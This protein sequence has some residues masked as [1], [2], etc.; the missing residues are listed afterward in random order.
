MF[1]FRIENREAYYT[2]LCDWWRQWG[3][4][5][6]SKSTVPNRIFVCYIEKRD[7]ASAPTRVLDL[8]AVPIYATDSSMVWLG[9]PTSNK[10]ASIEDKKGAL[11]YIMD[12]ISTCL[13][14]EGIETIITT[15]K[16]P[17]LMEAFKEEGY[18]ES[19]QGT[20]YYTKKL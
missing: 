10:S 15:S 7:S 18:Q 13:K 20:N 9:F 17:K 4:P 8:Y 5:I 12:V 1:K 2:T 16:T 14:Y 3:F 11:T 19:D 6:L